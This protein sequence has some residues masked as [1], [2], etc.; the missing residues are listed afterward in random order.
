M[1]EVDFEDIE[2]FYVY[3][4]IDYMYM[5]VNKLLSI[6]ICHHQFKILKKNH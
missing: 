5:N 1:Q 3:L 4:K 2:S 6:N